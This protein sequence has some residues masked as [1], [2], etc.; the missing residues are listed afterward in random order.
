VNCESQLPGQHLVLVVD[1]PVPDLAELRAVCR[2]KRIRLHRW[3]QGQNGNGTEFRGVVRDERES[4]LAWRRF[5]GSL[6]A[7]YVLRA[8]RTPTAV[9]LRNANQRPARFSARVTLLMGGHHV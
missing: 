3:Q 1:G 6:E 2:E 4:A 9:A 5:I 8:R 7:R